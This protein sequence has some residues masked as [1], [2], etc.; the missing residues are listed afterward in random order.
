MRTLSILPH[1]AIS[2][3]VN[4]ILVIENCYL[5]GGVGL[6]LIANGYPCILFLVT[7]AGVISCRNKKTG[8][9]LFIGQNIKP[10][11]IATTGRLTL[12]AYFLHPHICAAFF[13]C[14]ARELTDTHIDLELSRPAKEMNLGERLVNENGLDK[15]LT[16]LNSF[17]YKLS[18]RAYSDVNKGI[19]F[20][21][22]AIRQSAGDLPLRTIQSE[23]GVTERTFQRL[24]EWHVGVSP[25]MF[26]RICRFHSAFQQLNQRQFDNLSDIA[27]ENGYTDQS[28]FIRS[29]REFTHYTPKEYLKNYYDFLMLNP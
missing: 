16:L 6:P 17:V 15:R 9:L 12:I 25:R 26:G 14:S 5:Q 11:A 19:A 4:N 8:N 18:G 1:P 22:R 27:Y 2:D 20:A 7:D 23:L 10:A 29:F 24:F 13:G 21:T 3:Y 28:H